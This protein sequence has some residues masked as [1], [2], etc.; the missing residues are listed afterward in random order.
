MGRIIDLAGQKFGHCKKNPFRA[1]RFKDGK[2]VNLGRFQTALQ[3]HVA[4][5]SAMSGND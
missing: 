3:A 2:Q 4:F 5:L 1:N